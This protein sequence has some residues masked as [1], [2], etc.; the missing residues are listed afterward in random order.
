METMVRAQSWSGFHLVAGLACFLAAAQGCGQADDDDPQPAA[1]AGTAGSAGSTGAVGPGGAGSGEEPVCAAGDLRAC[2]ARR[3]VK[4]CDGFET[5]L[6]DRSGYGP[7]EC[8]DEPGPNGNGGEGGT[9][10]S[11]AGGAGGVEGGAPG[12]GGSAGTDDPGCV[13]AG[14]D[15]CNG[16][17]DDCDPATVDGQHEV[18]FGEPCDGNDA[19]LCTDGAF[20]CENTSQVC[21]EDATAVEEVCSGDGE[22]E[23]CDGEVDEGFD[24]DVFSTCSLTPEDLGPLSGDVTI[25]SPEITGHQEAYYKLQLTEDDEVT[26]IYLGLRIGLL[27]PPGA[28]FDLQVYCGSC[29][30]AAAKSS[31]LT[32]PYDEVEVRIDDTDVLDTTELVVHVK[33]YE[34]TIC[35]D[36][37]LYFRSNIATDVTPICAP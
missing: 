31:L 19:D 12:E 13:V 32:T 6:D 9:P 16:V 30:T 3:G 37:T 22:D 14:P 29:A 1:T 28:D 33:Y 2:V 36:W 35:S 18:W 17:D 20:T 5:C 7:C 23:D 25:Q 21:D 26:S 8:P 34:T 11:T 4:P 27:S 10:G 15:Y 24:A